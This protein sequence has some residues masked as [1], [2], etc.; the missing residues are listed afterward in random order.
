M[1]YTPRNTVL[2]KS[3]D[4]R[5]PFFTTSNYQCFETYWYMPKNHCTMYKVFTK[6]TCLCFNSKII[7]DFCTTSFEFQTIHYHA[8]CE[9]LH[10]FPHVKV[11]STI[12]Q[13]QN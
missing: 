5:Q 12:P 9:L 7:L 2:S 11:T 6:G 1:T 3:E 4:K 8:N 10:N 13:K